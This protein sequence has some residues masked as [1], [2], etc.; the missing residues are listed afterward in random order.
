M[1]Q[2]DNKK[3]ANW[4]IVM[5]SL[6]IVACGNST[7]KDGKSDNDDNAYFPSLEGAISNDTVTTLINSPRLKKTRYLRIDSA[8]GDIQ[9]AISLGRYLRE[10]NIGVLVDGLCLSSCAHFIFATSVRKKITTGSIVAFHGTATAR[11]QQLTISKRPDLAEFYSPIAEF[12]RDFYRDSSISEKLLTKPLELV[13]P[14]CYMAKYVDLRQSPKPIPSI[15]T[16][17]SFVF[18]S[19]RSLE[20]LGVRNIEGT[21]TDRPQ[22]LSSRVRL[23]LIRRKLSVVFPREGELGSEGKLLPIKKCG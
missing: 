22:N 7:T 8:G 4:L 17:A 15:V 10:H 6:A 9:A 11:S 12:E 20:N 19:K 23:S 13:L 5:L 3:Y 1:L 18:M 21:L 14:V 16:R 2:S